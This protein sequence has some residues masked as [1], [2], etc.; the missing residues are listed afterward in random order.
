VTCIINIRS[1]NCFCIKKKNGSFL[2][3]LHG[4]LTF[5]LSIYCDSFGKA[6]AVLNWGSF[7]WSFTRRKQTR[8]V[9]NA[10]ICDDSSIETNMG[11][12]NLIFPASQMQLIYFPLSV[13]ISSLS[14]ITHLGFKIHAGANRTKL[15]LASRIADLECYVTTLQYACSVTMTTQ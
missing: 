12:D 13:S 15:I 10:S 7:F 9:A 14:C 8:S 4:R 2:K 1:Y 6:G 5:P 3:Q 11:V